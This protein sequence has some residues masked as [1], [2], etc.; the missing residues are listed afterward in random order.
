MTAVKACAEGAGATA[1]REA[2]AACKGRR[3]EPAKARSQPRG[4]PQA[5][6]GGAGRWAQADGALKFGHRPVPLLRMY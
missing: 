3:G 4:Q 2:A 1:T 5:L 6:K